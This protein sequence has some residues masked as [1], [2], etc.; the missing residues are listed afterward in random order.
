[1]IHC[2]NC[3]RTKENCTCGL[4]FEPKEKL[5]GVCTVASWSGEFEVIIDHNYAAQLFKVGADDLAEPKE[6]VDFINE[7]SWEFFVGRKMFSALL[8]MKQKKHYDQ[9]NHPNEM[10]WETKI[11]DVFVQNSF[12]ATIPH[13]LWDPAKPIEQKV[14]SAVAAGCVVA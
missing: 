8:N 2:A 6:L 9:K 1:M 3:Y 4:K 12:D 13:A 7:L 11:V 10:V 5:F 14:V